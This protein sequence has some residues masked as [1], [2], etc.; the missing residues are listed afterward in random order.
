[1]PN[2]FKRLS[3]S[4]QPS[5]D[6]RISRSYINLLRSCLKVFTQ[7]LPG[8]KAVKRTSSRIQELFSLNPNIIRTKM[9]QNKQ[10]SEN[11]PWGN[12]G[13]SV[14]S[15]PESSKNPENSS[16]D[17]RALAKRCLKWWHD[18]LSSS[19]V[20]IPPGCWLTHSLLGL[21]RAK[22]S[23]KNT[24]TLDMSQYYRLL[25]LLLTARHGIPQGA[26]VPLPHLKCLSVRMLERSSN[27]CQ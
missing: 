19:G 13:R 23:K 8:L 17:P 24:C 1:M 16:K 10:M 18:L 2:P 3:K 7:A 27:N 6:L 25:R 21:S 4:L 9:G 22:K 14:K 15:I 5:N 26:P 20:H 11:G 12:L